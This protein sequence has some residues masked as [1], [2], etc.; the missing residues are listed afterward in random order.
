MRLSIVAVG[1]LRTAWR[2]AAD[3]YI[4]R[5]RRH[6]TLDEVE[7]REVGLDE[8]A[9][10][11]EAKVPAGAVVV[12]LDRDGQQFSSEALAR[13]LDA[14]RLAARPVACIIGGSHGLHPRLLQKASLRWSL[15]LLTLPHE[16]ARVVVLEQLYRAGTILRGEPYHK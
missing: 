4:R 7:V 3:D 6:V 2:A 16:L 14:W 12:A 1:R 15:G 11:L 13:Q 8:E 9:T 5:L 10:R